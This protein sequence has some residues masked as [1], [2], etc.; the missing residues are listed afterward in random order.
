VDFATPDAISEALL[1]LLDSPE[2]RKQL[3]SRARAYGQQ[4]LWPEVGIRYRSL[5]RAALGL[6]PRAPWNPVTTRPSQEALLS[7]AGSAVAQ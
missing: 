5:M 7:S 3:E 2:L 1:R 6:R 4:L